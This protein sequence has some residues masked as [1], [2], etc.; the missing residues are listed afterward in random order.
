MCD[1]VAT[2]ELTCDRVTVQQIE[3]RYVF[4]ILGKKAGDFSFQSGIAY[5]LLSF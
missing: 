1:M 4:T 5:H 3:K 2:A